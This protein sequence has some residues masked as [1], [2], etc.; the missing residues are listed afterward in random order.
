MPRDWSR[1]QLSDSVTRKKQNNEEE[2][3]ISKHHEDSNEDCEKVSSAVSSSRSSLISVDSGFFPCDEDFREKVE[4]ISA[5][6]IKL[7]IK[8][9]A[10]IRNIFNEKSSEKNLEGEIIKL[11]PYESIQDL[12]DIKYELEG[13]KD[14][15]GRLH[16]RCVLS[17][18]DGGEI[19][20]VWK[21]GVRYRI[22]QF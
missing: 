14:S 10:D 8:R 15:D 11:D 2:K 6:R 9:T 7:W 5:E 16:G 22:Y 21:H 19:F 13:S 20:G 1:G 3:C 18:S 12:D 4:S 17:L